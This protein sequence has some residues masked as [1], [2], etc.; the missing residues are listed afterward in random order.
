MWVILLSLKIE[1]LLVMT[2]GI[3]GHLS[4][5]DYTKSKYEKRIRITK[6][7]HTYLKQ[8]AGKDKMAAKLEEIINKHKN[9][10]VDLPAL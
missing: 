10:N 7:H 2:Q 9:E 4:M 3:Q 1:V 8:L 5:I 6:E